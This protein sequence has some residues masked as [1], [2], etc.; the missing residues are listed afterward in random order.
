MDFRDIGCGDGR[1]IEIAFAVLK[2]G[3]GNIIQICRI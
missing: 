1:W 3:I 2:L